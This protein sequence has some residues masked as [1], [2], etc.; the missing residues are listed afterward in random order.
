M[1][2]IMIMLRKHFRRE[3]RKPGESRGGTD[4]ESVC[5]LLVAEWDELQ[6]DVKMPED[7]QKRLKEHFDEKS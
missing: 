1:D 3:K 2:S 6:G 4:A 7:D 5:D